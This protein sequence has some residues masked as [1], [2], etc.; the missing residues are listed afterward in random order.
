METFG[1]NEQQHIF[2]G[3]CMYLLER[4][5]AAYNDRALVRRSIWGLL[6]ITAIILA[7]LGGLPPRPWHSLAQALPQVTLLWQQHGA[8]IILPLLLLLVQAID[9][10]LLWL[11]P[12]GG[13]ALAARHWWKQRHGFE[14]EFVDE[15]DELE[16]APWPD[17]PRASTGSHFA[18][19]RLIAG[20][21]DNLSGGHSF[22]GNSVR[23]TDKEVNISR[24]TAE[25]SRTTPPRLAWPEQK[26][27]TSLLD[28]ADTN[29]ATSGQIIRPPYWHPELA[30]SFDIG[31]SWDVGK[32]RKDRPNED[33]LVALQ[34]MCIYNNQL[35]PFGFFVVA[36]GMGGH[37]NGQ[38]ASY[39]AIQSLLSSVLPAIVGSDATS[40]E[41]LVE[42]LATGV[43]QANR[44]V[45]QRGQEVRSDMGTTITAALVVNTRA[46]VVNVGDSRTYL[47]RRCDGLLQITHDHSHV[48]RLVAAGQIARDDIYTHPERNQ[49]YRALGSEQDLEVDWFTLSLQGEDCLLLCSDGLWEM[50]RDQEIER[51]FQQRQGAPSLASKE[52]ERAALK[53]GGQDNISA[54]VVRLAPT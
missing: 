25:V 42:I 33:S 3:M 51:I 12:L 41:L 17:N 47:Y 16:L 19:S 8:A 31:A 48:A 6:P 44:V 22:S 27:T 24:P 7:L 53:G 15:P 13:A 50:V 5:L 23:R 18:A 20:E 39:L 10:A 21:P 4:F 45:Y 30:F 9:W 43:Q 28:Y 14:F 36:D 2:R 52:L 26:E 34:G 1:E 32:K 11:L 29:Y 37:A 40:D 54:I 38:D 46:F 49:I 35:C